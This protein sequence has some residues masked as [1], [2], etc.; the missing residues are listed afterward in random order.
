MLTLTLAQE[1]HSYI[2]QYETAPKRKIEGP[3]TTHL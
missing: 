2:K 3:F 1:I